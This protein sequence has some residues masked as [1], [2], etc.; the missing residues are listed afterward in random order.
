[1]FGMAGHIEQPDEGHVLTDAEHLH[2]GIRCDLG[3]RREYARERERVFG[4]CQRR[5][6]RRF[7]RYS[8]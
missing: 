2:T 7:R 3:H 6:A 8:N 4:H 5:G 1:M